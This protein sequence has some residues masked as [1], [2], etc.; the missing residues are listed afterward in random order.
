MTLTLD[1]PATITLPQA[2]EIWLPLTEGEAVVVTG[3]IAEDGE[4]EV[5][6]STL[7]LVSYE[8]KLGYFLESFNKRA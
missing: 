4:T 1:T 5:H 3:V 7:E 8:A 6:F 2:G